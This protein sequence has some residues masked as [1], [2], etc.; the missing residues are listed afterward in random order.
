MPIRGV[1]VR[2]VQPR[3]FK[4]RHVDMKT[5]GS[6]QDEGGGK[7]RAWNTGGGTQLKHTSSG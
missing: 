1:W 5:T 3:L 6:V 2:M 4:Q 7:Q